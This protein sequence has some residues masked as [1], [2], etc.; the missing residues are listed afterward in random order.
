MVLCA[1]ERT[2]AQEVAVTINQPAGMS[3]ARVDVHVEGKLV[4]LPLFTEWP[5]VVCA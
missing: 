4:C 3:D 2:S 1:G 5:V